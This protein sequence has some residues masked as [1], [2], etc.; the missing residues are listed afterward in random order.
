MYKLFVL[1][2]IIVIISFLKQRY[3]NFNPGIN[4]KQEQCNINS[5]TLN[6]VNSY[7]DK[8][9]NIDESKTFDI[10]N[11]QR[12]NCRQ[13]QNK[14]IYLSNDTKSYCSGNDIKKPKLKKY[15]IKNDFYDLFY[16]DDNIS[17]KN[18]DI[19]DITS[20]YPFDININND[21][22][23]DIKN[24]DNKYTEKNDLINEMKK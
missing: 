9:C 6:K 2:I 4:N 14:K 19:Y 13:F 23:N 21:T 3:E 15:N 20:P 1:I 10:I 18:N 12:I 5:K 8:N 7:F 22:I 17:Y 16:N 24:I 11:N